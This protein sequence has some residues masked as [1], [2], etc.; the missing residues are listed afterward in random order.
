MNKNAWQFLANQV[1]Y[2]MFNLQRELH[3]HINSSPEAQRYLNPVW[4][5]AEALI[6]A[7]RTLRD[8]CNDPV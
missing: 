4:I 1:L 3:K 5:A 6:E 7:A 2:D 8:S